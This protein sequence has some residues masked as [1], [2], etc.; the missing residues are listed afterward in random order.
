MDHTLETTWKSASAFVP[1]HTLY[2]QFFTQENLL[3]KHPSFKIRVVD[4]VL[5]FL[6][7]RVNFYVHTLVKSKEAQSCSLTNFQGKIL[8]NAGERSH[9]WWVQYIFIEYLLY[10]PS[11]I[12]F[13]FKMT[14]L[15]PV[16][17]LVP[18]P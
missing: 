13:S 12:L 9:C 3:Y 7:T 15:L 11:A 1:S 17:S 6:P 16:K 4:F 8:L 2:T 18:I 5:V 10:I 14:Q